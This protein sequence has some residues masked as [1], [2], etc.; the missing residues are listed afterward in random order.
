LINDDVALAND[1]VLFRVLVSGFGKVSD[2]ISD[3]R[4]GLGEDGATGVDP[5]RYSCV[6]YG[7]DADADADVVILT[8][9]P[10]KKPLPLLVPWP[11]RFSLGMEGGLSNVEVSS[12]VNGDSRRSAMI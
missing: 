2:R 11:G 3:G 9:P 8:P 10:P 4:P 1:E 7:V 5:P 6:K 12:L